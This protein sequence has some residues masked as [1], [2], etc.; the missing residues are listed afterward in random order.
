MNVLLLPVL[1]SHCT[2]CAFLFCSVLLSGVLPLP[3]QCNSLLWCAV[4][5]WCAVAVS[6]EKSV[7]SQCL[8]LSL[9][10]KQVVCKQAAICD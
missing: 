10:C 3:L 2:W 9:V 7:R 5:V 8:L 6:A 4:T 1:R